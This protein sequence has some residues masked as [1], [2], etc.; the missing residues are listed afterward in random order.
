VALL[1][2]FYVLLVAGVITATVAG[3]LVHDIQY[4]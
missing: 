4:L 3:L 1:A 2:G